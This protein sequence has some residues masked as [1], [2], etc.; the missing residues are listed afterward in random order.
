M[1]FFDK[2]NR[3]AKTI[4][5]MTNEAIESRKE[6]LEASRNNDKLK[7]DREAVNEQYRIIGEYYY[8][9]YAGGGE[10]APEL[11][12][13]CETAKLHLEAIAAAEEE[14]RIRREEEERLR[15]EAELAAQAE[16]EGQGGNLCPVCGAQNGEGERFCGDCGAKLQPEEPRERTCPECGSAVQPGKRF[17]GECGC[18]MEE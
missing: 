3:V 4:G 17:C 16:A 14:E 13:A 5:E 11:A 12:Q 15:R 10:I 7:A 1:A 9:V 6:A 8:N 18:K 2:L